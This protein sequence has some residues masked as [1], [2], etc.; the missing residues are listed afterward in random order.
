MKKTAYIQ[1]KIFVAIVDTTELFMS[2][3]SNL[4]DLDYYGD[5]PEEMSADVRSES[6]LWDGEWDF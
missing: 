4:D 1:P 2:M 5:A 6:F 3:S